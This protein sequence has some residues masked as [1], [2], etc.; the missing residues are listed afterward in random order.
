MISNQYEKDFLDHAIKVDQSKQEIVKR[1]KEKIASLQSM[2]GPYFETNANRK[3]MEANAKKLKIINVNES[4]VDTHSP[5]INPPLKK[6]LYDQ[7]YIKKYLAQKAFVAANTNF[8]STP[9]RTPA[10]SLKPFSKIAQPPSNDGLDK[11][12]SRNQDQVPASQSLLN[13]KLG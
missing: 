5:V 11:P 8:D 13:Q 2:A 12:S 7:D 10:G 3:R 9:L 6:P 1:H 4:R